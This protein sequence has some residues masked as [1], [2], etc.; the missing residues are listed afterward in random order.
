MIV[1][2]L[3]AAALVLM[4]L[5]WRLWRQSRSERRESGLP[6]GRLI[7]ADTG[8]WRPVRRPLFSPRYNLTGKPDYVLETGAGLIPV[9]VK[10]AAGP[11]V[12]H[13]GHLLQL[14]AYCL[15]VEETSGRTPAHGLLQYQDRL[16]EVDFSRELRQELLE[17][18]AA[19][20]ADR[21][22]EVVARSHRS[23]AR[24]RRCGF[25]AVCDEALS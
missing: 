10:S 15:L 24:C 18:M 19:I 16:F 25:K 11:A 22:L 1:S 12:P 13:L 7:Y 5:G 3:W 14:A 9:E 20:R 8:S 4:G 17:T 6:Q 23:E 21:E 2:C